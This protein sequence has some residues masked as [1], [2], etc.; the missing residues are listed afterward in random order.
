VKALARQTPAGPVD[1]P[2]VLVDLT[3]GVAAAA[4]VDPSWLAEVDRR[5]AAARAAVVAAGRQEELEAALHTVLLAAT[6][7]VDAGIDAR[8]AS[9]ACL[10]ILA[11][12]VASALAG[13]P[14]PFH[15]WGR[16]VAAGWWPIGPSGG[17]LVVSTST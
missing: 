3:A 17:R 13:P 7:P 5:R 8:V 1:L 12:A 16:L 6:T 2:L 15:A 10:W 9:G 11:G 14:D 4:E